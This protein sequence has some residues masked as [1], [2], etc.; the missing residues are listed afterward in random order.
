MKNYRNSFFSVEC[1]SVTFGCVGCEF[2]KKYTKD[3]TEKNTGDYQKIFFLIFSH[4]K[5][6]T[7]NGII[8]SIQLIKQK[9]KKSHTFRHT[10]KA[11][12]SQ[13]ESDTQFQEITSPVTIFGEKFFCSIS[14][15]GL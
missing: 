6:P 13:T 11:E 3:N 9:N 12:L 15:I 5:H 4:P 1:D 8:S 7:K 10:H 2:F 14:S